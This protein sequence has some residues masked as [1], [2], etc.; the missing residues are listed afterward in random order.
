[1]TSCPTAGSSNA[2]VPAARTSAPGEPPPPVA[3]ERHDLLVAGQVAEPHDAEP[4]H[5]P[6]TVERPEPPGPPGRRRARAGRR[7]DAARRRDGPRAAPPGCRRHRPG[8]TAPSRR[9]CVEL[10]CSRMPS[11]S[12]PGHRHLRRG[13]VDVALDLPARA[14]PRRRCRR[15][16][17]RSRPR[18]G[19]RPGTP[20]SKRATH[21]STSAE[22]ASPRTS[23]KLP[24]QKVGLASVRTTRWSPWSVT[25]EPCSRSSSR[26]VTRPGLSMRIPRS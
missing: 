25:V 1:M 5:E 16:A 11:G 20:S 21:R 15:P 3:L 7:R 8:P 14:P 10:A 9:R 18:G 19:A 22:R 23:T 24:H 26:S 12:V 13:E 17:A 4:G 6:V 2:H